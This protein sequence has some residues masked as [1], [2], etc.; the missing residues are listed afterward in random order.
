MTALDPDTL[1]AYAHIQVPPHE[2]FAACAT[3]GQRLDLVNRL[4]GKRLYS[5]DAADVWAAWLANYA[6]E[7]G[8]EQ[9]ERTVREL[10]HLSPNHER[11]AALYGALMQPREPLAAGEPVFMITSCVKYL[12]KAQG[13][14]RTLRAQGAQAWIVTGNP[15]LVLPQWSEAICTVAVDDSYEALPLKV[16]LG[17]AA[18]VQRFGPC[19]I[20]KIDDDCQPTDKFAVERFKRIGQTFDYVGVAITDPHHDRLWHRGKTSHELGPYTRRYN[21]PWAR[22]A[23]YLLSANASDLVAREVTYYPGEFACE[24][25]EDKAIGDFLRRQGFSLRP[26]NNDAEWG[27]S[28]DIDERYLVP[29][30]SAEVVTMPPPVSAA[31][32]AAPTR[33]PMQTLSSP[34]S[35]HRERQ[36]IPKVLHLTWVGDASKRPDNCIQTWIDQNPG[37]TVKIWGNDDLH[38]FEWVNARHIRQM[39]NKE[40]N[41]VADLMRWEIL[42]S[43]GGI[44]VDADSICVRPLDDWILEAE[45]I[46]CW[47]NEHTRPR[48]IG[49]NMVGSVPENP[50]IGQIIKDLQAEESVVNDMAWKTVGPLRLTTAYFKYRYTGLT[51]LPSH[52]FIPDHFSGVHYDGRGIVYAKQEWASTH[53]AYDTL[54]MKR[55]A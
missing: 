15:E 39:W 30:A 41:G 5:H 18:I 52:F 42:Y 19:T 45:V 33:V 54:H 17:M 20:V 40:L 4:Y 47:E 29:Q 11:A 6:S 35:G 44:V 22:G 9:V 14:L 50:F 3:L 53:H 21:G 27:I 8:A 12:H 24:F 25:Y 10:L 7:L 51:I 34:E 23:C 49:C 28:F 13:L 26:L 43:E 55:F 16:A 46:A 1:A 31:P 38:D 2:A 32:D 37:W 36:L 48:L